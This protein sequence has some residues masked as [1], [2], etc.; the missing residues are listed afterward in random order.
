MQNQ[1]E[2]EG[3]KTGSS[4]YHWM[5]FSEELKKKICTMNKVERNEREFL[6]GLVVVYVSQW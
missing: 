1:E 6:E 2:T 3:A 5:Q 4:R